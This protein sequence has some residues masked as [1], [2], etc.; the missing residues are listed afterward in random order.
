MGIIFLEQK[1]RILSR[2][3]CIYALSQ[4]VAHSISGFSKTHVYVCVCVCVCVFFFFL[5]H[6]SHFGEGFRPQV[7]NFSFYCN[8]LHALIKLILM[9]PQ[10]DL[11]LEV[12]KTQVQENAKNIKVSF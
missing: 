2:I 11:T 4:N 5:N 10:I 1:I 7:L 9:L 8:M 3:V 6:L 12:T